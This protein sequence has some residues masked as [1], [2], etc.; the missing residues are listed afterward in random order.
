M[1]E[2]TYNISNHMCSTARNGALLHDD[3]SIL[4]MLGNRTGSALKDA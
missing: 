2:K 1:N 3:G 4:R